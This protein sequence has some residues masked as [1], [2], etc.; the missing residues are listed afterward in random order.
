M[1]VLP[2]TKLHAL[3]GVNSLRCQGLLWRSAVGNLQSQ[4]L[5][6][7]GKFTRAALP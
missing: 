3:A 2:T 6:S 5:N 7:D 4:L 1:L